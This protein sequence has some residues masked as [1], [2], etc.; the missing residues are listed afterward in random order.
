MEVCYPSILFTCKKINKRLAL[1]AFDPAARACNNYIPVWFCTCHSYNSE[2]SPHL[3]HEMRA[4]RHLDESSQL[5]AMNSFVNTLTRNDILDLLAK[6]H[7]L[8]VFL[9]SMNALGRSTPSNLMEPLEGITMFRLELR[10]KMSHLMQDRQ[11]TTV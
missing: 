11:K 2:Q 3:Q 1:S 9:R 10:Q 6:Q 4:Q 8:N 5:K 7:L